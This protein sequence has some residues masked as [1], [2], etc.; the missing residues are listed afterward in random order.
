MIISFIRPFAQL[1]VLIYTL[2]Q[3]VLAYKPHK[4]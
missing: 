2:D 4:C 3:I 1:P